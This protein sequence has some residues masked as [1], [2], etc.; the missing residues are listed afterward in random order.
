MPLL[1]RGS[2]S[3]PSWRLTRKMP[4]HAKQQPSIPIFGSEEPLATVLAAS[5]SG[6]DVCFDCDRRRHRRRVAQRAARHS[7]LH[8]VRRRAP[9][10]RRPRVLRALAPARHAEGSRSSSRCSSAATPNS[11]NGSRRSTASSATSGSRCRS[12]CATTP[13]AELWRQ[14]MRAEAAGEALPTELPRG[15]RPR[16]A[17][18]AAGAAGG[19]AGGAGAGGGGGG[20]AHARAGHRGDLGGGRDG[21]RGRGE[22]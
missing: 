6:N 21:G 8:P 12:S 22:V 10:A 14:R 15:D 4:K 19:G 1:G 9:L 16:R 11:A 3:P 5:K 20:S 7:P 2:S 13:A 17:R 18:A